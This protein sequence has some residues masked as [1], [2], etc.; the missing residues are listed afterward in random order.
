MTAPIDHDVVES[1]ANAPIN[2][3]RE[4]IQLSMQRPDLVTFAGGLPA[5]ELFDVEG[6][7][8][9]TQAAMRSG[10][11]AR[12]ATGCHRSAAVWAW[13]SRITLCFRT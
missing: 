7:E 1:V 8:A 13:F 4:L 10:L 6:L 2:V 12:T 3:L 11:T 9:A 5:D